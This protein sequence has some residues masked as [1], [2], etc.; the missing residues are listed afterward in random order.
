MEVQVIQNMCLVQFLCVKN[1]YKTQLFTAYCVLDES[2]NCYLANTYL[3]LST[4]QALF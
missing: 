2:V 3:A 1:I 4:C